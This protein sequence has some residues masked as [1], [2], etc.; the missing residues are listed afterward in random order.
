L[1]EERKFR[2]EIHVVRIIKILFVSDRR[3][4]ISTRN[5]CS[6]NFKNALRFCQKK[7]NFDKKFM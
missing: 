5:S 4:R 6:E 1:S 7:E 2:Q 3:N